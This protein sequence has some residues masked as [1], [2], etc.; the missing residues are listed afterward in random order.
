MKKPI[1]AVYGLIKDRQL[2]ELKSIAQEYDV[3][4]KSDIKEADYS[5]IQ[6]VYGWDQN[7]TDKLTDNQ[8]SSLKWIQKDTAGLDAIPLDIRESDNVLISNMSGIHAVPISENV[9]GYI[10]GSARGIFSSVESKDY[11][12]WKKQEITK[13]IFSLKDKKILIFGTG[14]I[15]QRIAKVSRFHEMHTFGVNSNGREIE[16]FEKVYDPKEVSKII[17]SIDF[18]VNTMPRTPQTINL[19]NKNFFNKMKRESHFINVGRGESVNENDLV[20]ALDNKIIRSAYI[21][22]AEVEPIPESSSLWG[23]K[24]LVITPHTSGIVEHFRESTFPIFKENLIS[25]LTTGSLKL[26]QYNRQKGY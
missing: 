2:E 25:F 16:F 20:Y 24:N 9:I 19:F 6:I 11:K 7:L 4:T 22:V 21:D 13:E 8:L 3:K 5:L 18:V 10:L 15:G 14:K 26:N 17:D 1:I 23:A 12:K